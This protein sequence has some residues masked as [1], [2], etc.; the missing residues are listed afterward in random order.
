MSHPHSGQDHPAVVLPISKALP[1]P[2]AGSP[3]LLKPLIHKDCLSSFLFTLF[4]TEMMPHGSG[5]SHLERKGPTGGSV[6]GAGRDTP[7]I[8]LTSMLGLREVTTPVHA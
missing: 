5:G 1:N 6:S 8:W 7:K 4:V 3:P 2:R